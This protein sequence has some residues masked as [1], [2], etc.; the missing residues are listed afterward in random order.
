MTEQRRTEDALRE[1]EARYRNI[2]DNME[3]AYYEVDLRGNMTFLNTAAV[4]SLGYTDDEMMGMNFRQ[5]ADSENA[6]KLREAYNRVFL[7]GESVKGLDWEIISK[8]SG[9]MPSRVR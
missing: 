9:K 4:T 1:S 6:N 2:L 7:T 8:D 3:E 5:Y